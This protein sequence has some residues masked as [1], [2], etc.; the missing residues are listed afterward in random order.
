MKRH[1]SLLLTAAFLTPSGLQADPAKKLP[2]SRTAGILRVSLP[3]NQISLVS[4]PMVDR[5]VDC[6]S[7]TGTPTA[8]IG[9]STTTLGNVTTNPHS[10]Q[11]VSGDA[12]G[13]RLRITASTASS[14]TVAAPIAGLAAGDQYIIVP[15]D[16]LAS[17][18]GATNSAGL[19]GAAG[20]AGADEVYIQINGVLT[21]FFYKSTGLGGTGWRRIAN[22]SGA[23]EPNAAIDP[24]TGI[25]VLRKAGGSPVNLDITGLAVTGR[26]KPPVA[27]G[28][29][30]LSNP[31]TL[32]TTL[33]K[34]G[35]R[36]FINGGTGPAT[37]DIIY[38]ENGG[39][40]TG[41]FFKNGG[42]GGTGWRLIDNPSGPN[43]DSIV[44]TPGKGILF[45][46]QAGTAAFTMQEPF[47]E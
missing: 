2:V 38:L 4:L 14:V 37:A 15:D 35:L 29:N 22:P 21:G 39:S 36:D 46:E 25:Y 17:I 28:F 33:G 41:Y 43:Q 18:F 1:L 26:Q 45:Q 5:V 16:T 10:I 13:V 31:F 19:L 44:L 40:F 12:Y 6:G 27:S 20:A 47:T 42:L 7:V 34:S 9:L 24:L 30:I 32:P 23:S 8:T 3:P 11:I